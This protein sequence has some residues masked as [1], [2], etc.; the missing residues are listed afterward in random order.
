MCNN[1]M[2]FIILYDYYYIL[3]ASM[4]SCPR[5]QLYFFEM[6]DP[7]L[8]SSTISLIEFDPC[9]YRIFLVLVH[10]YIDNK[11]TMLTRTTS[12]IW[13]ANRV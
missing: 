9:T 6:I 2:V 13:N 10:K 8:T 11:R 7:L 3:V 1:T 12:I 5:S 4:Q